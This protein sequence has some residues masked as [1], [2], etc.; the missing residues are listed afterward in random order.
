MDFLI[1]NHIAP[2]PIVIAG[3]LGVGKRSVERWISKLEAAHWLI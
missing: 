3:V 2:D 1:V